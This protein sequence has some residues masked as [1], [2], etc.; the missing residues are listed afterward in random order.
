MGGYIIYHPKRHDSVFDGQRIYYDSPSGNQDPFIW[1]RQFLHS[2]C[3]ITQMSPQVGDINFWVSGD[4]FPRFNSLLC[5]LVFV[6]QEKHYWPIANSISRTDPIVDSVTAYRDHYRWAMYQHPLK[7]RRRF[8]LKADAERS[9]QPQ[10]STNTL[11][12]IVPTLLDLGLSLEAVQC[13]LRAGFNSRPM[14]LDDT[15]ANVLY[16]WLHENAAQQWRG[17]A[18]AKMRRKYPELASPSPTGAPPEC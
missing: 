3:H 4:T 10:T 12:D 11:F 17:A 14:R 16:A 2:Y 15:Q 5:D 18:L 6:V 9:F 1:N 7:R 13:G 8:T